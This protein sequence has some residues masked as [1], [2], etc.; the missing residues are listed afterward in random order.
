MKRGDVVT[1]ATPGDQGGPR[2]AV[3]VRS[4]ALSRE[5]GSVIVCQLTPALTDAPAFRIDVEPS[6]QTRLRERFQVMA[7][8]PVT[9]RRDRI[10]R[11]IGRLS[12]E[13]MRRLNAALALVM[14][15]AD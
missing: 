3:I 1:V 13:E 15:L 6:E 4:D 10:R 11:V 9:V 14:G 2:P 12:P 7:D 5:H 8:K